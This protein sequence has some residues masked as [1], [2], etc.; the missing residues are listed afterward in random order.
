MTDKTPTKN[1]IAEF[2]PGALDKAMNS[3]QSF[4]ERENSEEDEEQKLTFKQ[5]HE[6]AKVALAHI[7]LLM[8]LAERAGLDVDDNRAEDIMR[9]IGNAQIEVNEKT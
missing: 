4:M 1:Q 5:H 9:M 3:Y 8:K 7:E 2:L 6:A